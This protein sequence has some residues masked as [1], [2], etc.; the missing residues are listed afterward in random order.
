MTMAELKDKY[1]ILLPNLS[2]AEK[3]WL[4]QVINS[5]GWKIVVKLANEG[6]D[7]FT[8]DIVKVP[9]EHPEYERI[10]VER[11]RRAR[12]ASEFSD[13]L[14]KS[15]HEHA[16]SVRRKEAQEE[17][18]AVESVTAIFGIHAKEPRVGAEDAI[19]SVYG[20][21]SAKPKK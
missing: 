8:R 18:E 6:C 15:V 7:T 3:T 16:D 9:Q 20:I 4:V 17:Q 1:T 19:K 21:H 2:Q 10:V 12:N 5:P 13:L 14:M 11:Q